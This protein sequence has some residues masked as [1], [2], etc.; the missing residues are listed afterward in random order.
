MFFTLLQGTYLYRAGRMRSTVLFSYDM[1]VDLGLD[2]SRSVTYWTNY[3]VCDPVLFPELGFPLLSSYVD[4]PS[5]H[6]RAMYLTYVTERCIVPR[7]PFLSCHMVPCS[8][9]PAWH[10]PVVFPF[11]MTSVP[12]LSEKSKVVMRRCADVRD[13]E[14]APHPR[15]F[16]CVLVCSCLG[17][18][19]VLF[20]VENV[21]ALLHHLEV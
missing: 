3:A 2:V 17:S 5:I 12:P 20:R 6:L 10:I 14:F 4:Q 7:F 19:I 1:L 21:D 18:S 9:K 15:R 16:C 13:A 8:L 11:P